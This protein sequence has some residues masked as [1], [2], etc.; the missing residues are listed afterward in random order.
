MTAVQAMAAVRSHWQ[1]PSATRADAARRA[2]KC[3]EAAADPQADQEHG[4]D[5]GE[6]VH[7][8]AEHQREQAGPD[9]LG[10]QRRHP[11]EGDRQIH[12]PGAGRAPAR[13]VRRGLGRRLVPGRG[14]RQGQGDRGHGHIEGEGDVGGRGHVV[15]A[16]QVEAGQQAAEH[17]PGDVAAVEEAQPRHPLGAGL[18]PARDRRQRRAHQQRGRQQAHPGHGPAQQ[19]ARRAVA[20]VT[21]VDLFDIR[22]AEQHREPDGADAQ[23]EQ[24]VDPQGVPPARDEPRQQQAARAHAAHERPQQHA[25]GDGGRADHQLQELEPDDLV[26]QRRTAAADEQHE[27][28]GQ[29][30]ARR[31]RAG[32]RGRVV[33]GHRAVVSERTIGLSSAKRISSSGITCALADAQLV[34]VH[35]FDDD[36]C[37]GKPFGQADSAPLRRSILFA[38]PSSPLPIFMNSAEPRRKWDCDQV[39]IAHQP[40]RAARPRRISPRWYD[41]LRPGPGRGPRVRGAR[42]ARAPHSPGSTRGPIAPPRGGGRPPD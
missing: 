33:W 9:H 36:R 14:G 27:Q 13:S 22:H 25:E 16:Q 3:P 21:H 40:H 35:L 28:H 8:A 10:A 23:L 15:D 41:A 30:P 19:D 18:D 4:Q 7:G 11:G 29:K 12:G 1:A 39:G 32:R 24:G 5:Q 31:G 20:G 37:I 34:L 38:A 6:G 42:A 2:R 26:D 17:G